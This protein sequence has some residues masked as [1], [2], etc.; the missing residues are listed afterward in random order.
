MT[1][2]AIEVKPL[3]GALGAEVSGVDL[4]GTLSE[5]VLEE[6]QQA[7][8]EH[9]VIVFREQI[10]TPRKQVEIAHRFGNPAIYPFLKGLDDAPQVNEVLKTETD[11]VNFGGSWHSD[12][13]YK[14]RPDLGTLLYAHEVPRYGGDTL[15]ANM[16]LAYEALSDAM[17]RLAAGLIAVNNSEKGYGGARKARLQGLAGLKDAVNEEIVTYEAEHP[18]VRTHPQ[19]GRKGLYVSRS[20]TLRFKDM[21]VEESEPLINY[22]SDFAVRPEFTCRLR[23][24]PRTLAI[25]D[26]RCTQHFAINDYQGQRRRMHR[27]TIEGDRPV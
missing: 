15:F 11:T 6:I 18:V 4:A 7:F 22:L 3:A 13:A 25:W 5:R 24:Q 8:L 12:T 1:Y 16:Y 19:T 10:L 17:K 14:E 23:W 21:S 26:N 9:L 20:H 2:H 27:V